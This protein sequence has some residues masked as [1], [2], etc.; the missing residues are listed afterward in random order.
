MPEEIKIPPP[1]VD[2]T[3][4]NVHLSYIRRDVD[5]IK[6]TLKDLKN[7]YVSQSDFVEHLKVADDHESRIRIL[8]EGKWKIAGATGVIVG[9]ISI[10]GIYIL[11]LITK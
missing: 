11:K 6:A 4:M 3:N 10:F 9:I 2:S 1:I 8:E 5:E 7:G